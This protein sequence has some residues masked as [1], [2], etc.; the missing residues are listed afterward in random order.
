MRLVL[1]NGLFWGNALVAVLAVGIA[2]LGASYGV[3]WKRHILALM[4]GHHLSLVSLFMVGSGC[5]LLV[6][7]AFGLCISWRLR[8]RDGAKEGGLSA[9]RGARG[10]AVY[11]AMALV[12]IA[13]V[14]L[15]AIVVHRYVMRARQDVDEDLKYAMYQYF[16]D[17]SS[18]D[19]LDSLH[20][21]FKCCGVRNYTD[22]TMA[23]T[24]ADLAEK[25]RMVAA[26]SSTRTFVPRT[27][28]VVESS[29]GACLKYHEQGC[30]DVLVDYLN[31]LMPSVLFCAICVAVWL[32]T[33]MLTSHRLRR[34]LLEN[35]NI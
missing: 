22:W 25:G 7:S 4:P 26:S 9:E 10:C 29:G 23:T 13:N 16:V 6:V 11:N 31:M 18:R 19:K 2:V 30:R 15:S 3:R 21:E 34:I 28:C 5:V 33:M 1:A 27:C 12:V 32:S 24:G 8:R 35:P 14:A 20:R 17:A